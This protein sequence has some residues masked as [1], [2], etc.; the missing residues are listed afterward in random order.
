MLNLDGVING[1]L[2]HSLSGHDLNRRVT[3]MQCCTLRFSMAKACRTDEKDLTVVFV[4]DVH[5]HSR[6]HGVFIYGCTRQANY[7]VLS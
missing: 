2:S 6:K 4:L 7:E 3:L 5:G 1:K